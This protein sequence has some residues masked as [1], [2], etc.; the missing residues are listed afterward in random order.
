MKDRWINQKEYAILILGWLFGISACY[1]EEDCQKKQYNWMCIWN[2]LLHEFSP[3]SY[4][5]RAEILDCLAK[6][7]CV[8][9]NIVNIS[10]RLRQAS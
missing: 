4:I 8:F 6:V 7:E 9:L 5:N 3:S 1:K 2:T 10:H